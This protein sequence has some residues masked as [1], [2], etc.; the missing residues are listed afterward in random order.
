MRKFIRKSV[1]LLF[2]VVLINLSMGILRIMAEDEITYVTNRKEEFVTA[3][4]YYGRADTSVYIKTRTDLGHDSINLPKGILRICDHY[5]FSN[6][7]ENKTPEMLYIGDSFFDDPHVNSTEGIQALT[8]KKMQR[9]CAYNI[10][11]NGCSG[12][13]VYNELDAQ[14]FKQKPKVIFFESVER[15]LATTIPEALVHLKTGQFKSQ[16]H[17]YFGFDLLLG[18]NFKDLKMSKLFVK[19]QDL[20]YGYIKTV[21]GQKVWFLRN[22]RSVYAELNK[23]VEDMQEIQT[24]LQQRGIKVVFVV[25]PDKESLYPE[26]F[27]RSKIELMNELMKAKKME[28]L[29]IYSEMMKNRSLYY[30]NTDTHWNGRAIDLLTN[31]TTDYYLKNYKALP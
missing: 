29:D 23:I 16:K 17:Q 19:P 28:F 10:G 9:N 13:K 12:F 1:L 20:K 22:K 25:A 21:D 18:S 27:G 6:V 7:A 24:I 5:G 3:N 15:A 2:I 26:L 11:A 31:L 8:N 4:Q 30:Y 14:Y